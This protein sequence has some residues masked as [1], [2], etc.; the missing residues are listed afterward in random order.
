M[1]KNL[2]VIITGALA[3]MACS[4]SPE[5]K[6]TVETST[7]STQEA[8]CEP[9]KAM[10][11]S[12]QQAEITPEAKQAAVLAT[13]SIE[14]GHSLKEIQSVEQQVVAGMNYKVNF[15]IEDGE[16]YSATVFRNLKGEYK[17]ISV[18][19]QALVDE[20]KHNL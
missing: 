9:V 12:W 11:G 18:Q 8:I 1:H 15:T 10:P 7:A 20:C 14:G 19:P 3:L 4:S 16:A 6:D 17:L 5:T 2:F 13:A